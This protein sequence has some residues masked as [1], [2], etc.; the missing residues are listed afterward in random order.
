MPNT[1]STIVRKLTLPPLRRREFDI[2]S[3][4]CGFALAVTGFTE[5]AGATATAWQTTQEITAVAETYLRDKIGALAD[6]TTVQ[7]DNL[8]S[9][10]RLTRCSEPLEPYL[11]RGTEVKART[12]VGVRCSG[13]KP[14]K[15]YV[16]VNVI[17]TETV[18][19]ANR[20]LPR[21][22]Q[23]SA[24]DLREE[25]RDVSRLIAGYISDKRQLSGQTLKTQLIAG[26]IL[27]PG[28]L[29]AEIAIRRGQTVTLTAGSGDFSIR[30]S[31]KALMDGAVSQ[32]IR[33]ENIHSGRIVEGIVRS[34]EHVE[35]LI[36]G[37]DH[38]LSGRPKESARAA[39][40]RLSN[41]DR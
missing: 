11:R 1:S 20:T 24:A 30:M 22:H 4:L 28:M 2:L 33:V 6:R 5:K 29:Q 37:N 23:L 12:I 16:P 8:D 14:W 3:L 36:S 41:N 19:V 25:Q 38:F 31:G 15:V 26:K 40:T 39:D 18:L 27:T 10:H 35:V 9:R 34:R 21:G 17:V 32:R 7:A 13:N